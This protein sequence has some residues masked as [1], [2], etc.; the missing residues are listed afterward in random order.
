MLTNPPVPYDFCVGV[1]TSPINRFA[2]LTHNYITL[3]LT[4]IT[5]LAATLGGK[6]SVCLLEGELEGELCV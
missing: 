3:A 2:A 5:R 6:Y 1:P 4:V